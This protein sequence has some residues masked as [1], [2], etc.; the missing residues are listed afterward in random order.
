MGIAHKL[1]F[2]TGSI[3]EKEQT[4]L[5]DTGACA[6]FLNSHIVPPPY[7]STIAA[8]VRVA[9]GSQMNILGTVTCPI[10]FKK[11]TITQIFYVVE[12]CPLPVVLGNDFLT[13]Y[14]AVISYPKKEIILNNQ[15]IIDFY[16]K[17]SVSE[18]NSFVVEQDVFKIR[19][20]STLTIPPRTI[21]RVPINLPHNLPQESTLVIEPI[22]SLSEKYGLQ[23]NPFILHPDNMTNT[24]LSMFL[25]NREPYPKLVPRGLVLAC[26][27]ESSDPDLTFITPDPLPPVVPKILNDEQ[28]DSLNINPDLPPEEISKIR[29]LLRSYG[30]VFA[31]S[32]M[33]LKVCPRF[34]YTIDTGNATPIHQSPYRHSL[35]ERME[36]QRQVEQMIAAGIVEPSQS[37]W[38]SPIVLVPKKTGDIRLCVDF[39]KLNLVTKKDSY[40]LTRIDDILDATRQANV[41][42]CLD[43]RQGY[44]QFAV[45]PQDREKTSFITPDGLYNYKRLPFGLACAPSF[46]Q[47]AMNSIFASM[48]FNQ[49]LIYLD[50]LVV[51]GKGFDDHLDKLK[52]VLQR[53]AENYLSLQPSKCFFGYFQIELLGHLVSGE[54]VKPNPAKVAAVNDLRPPRNAKETRRFVGMAGYYRRFIPN[55]A[56]KARPL[57]D[58]WKKNSKFHWNESH[59][60]AFDCLKHDL[61]NAPCLAHH[62]PELTQVLRSDAC[63]KGLGIILAQLK[64]GVEQ[65]V[66]YASRTLT[67][68]ESNYSISEKECLAVVFGV[69]RFRPYLYGKSF[70]VRVDHHAL[71]YL[72]SVKDL[73]SR[74]AKFAL[75][76]Q[77]YEFEVQY[78]SGKTHVDADCLSRHHTTLGTEEDEREDNELPLNSIYF[79]GNRQNELK[80]MQD[81][82]SYIM[83]IKKRLQNP[84]SSDKNEIKFLNNF[85]TKEGVLLRQTPIDKR[86]RFVVP[87][88]MRDLILIQNHDEPISGHLGYVKTADKVKKRYWWPGIDKDI[89]NYVLTCPKCLARKPTSQKP[90]GLLQPIK[91][92]QLWERIGIDLLGPFPESEPD[93]E[94]KVTFKYLI[95]ATDYV[96]RYVFTRPIPSKEA[97]HVSRFL[98][99]EI[100]CKVGAPRW[101]I[102]DGGLEF[103]NSTILNLLTSLGIGKE[104]ATPYHSQTS[105]AT[106]RNNRTFSE[107]VS[108]YVSPKYS[109]TDWPRFIPHLTMA[110]N[111]STQATTKMSP[112]YLVYGTEPLLPLDTLLT[113]HLDIAREVQ[114]K[115]LETAR[116]T[117]VQRTV[118]QQEKSKER[119]DSTHR[120]QQY[121]EGDIVRIFTPKR[122]VGLSDKLLSR[123]FGP[124]RIIKKHSPLNYEVELIDHNGRAKKRDIVHVSRIRRSPLRSFSDDDSSIANSPEMLPTIEEEPQDEIV[125]NIPKQTKN[126]KT[127]PPIP[128][129]NALGK[130][131]TRLATG[132]LKPINYKV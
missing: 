8:R 61:C 90:A 81:E 132:A 119:Y 26:V 56:S 101:I 22:K 122:I 112:Y 2:C 49:V 24:E 126:P 84:T 38:A 121:K 80:A 20:P 46:F 106:E 15:N 71:C 42:S 95:V 9:N 79:T 28:L 48:T 88:N 17:T 118:D 128:I 66:A 52:S 57:I 69:R 103:I 83:E 85:H 124:Y 102:S 44:N 34:T 114:L 1:I 89:M 94:T 51:P 35:A 97:K 5:I 30:H 18:Q 86:P 72:R 87:F 82:D 36:I 91:T 120:D 65:P 78:R 10:K 73:N 125:V 32:P 115:E 109:H 123:N 27:E 3:N 4:C 63:G 45:A 41:F 19:N 33:D 14:S 76:L 47:R 13:K 96:S 37:A 107:M 40:P 104:T 7:K 12:D 50:D 110:Y 6:S 67:P 53:L 77:P 55:F 16:F 23:T 70:I 59:Q 111:V 21:Q 43:L 64:D 100:F 11:F 54:G 131:N 92:Y 117:A 99:E 98:L 93:P 129:P 29:E 25:I 75:K 113:P 127:L 74:L 62:D 116:K 108:M 39:R 105:G 130:R 68:A 31:W 60:R 58:L